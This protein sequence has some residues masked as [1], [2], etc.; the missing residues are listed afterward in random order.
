MRE[1]VEQSNVFH[2]AEALLDALL[3]ALAVLLADGVTRLS[4]GAPSMAPPPPAPCLA[5]AMLME[6][7]VL[8]IIAGIGITFRRSAGLRISP[9]VSGPLRR[10]Q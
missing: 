3:D 9:M 10:R 5:P 2:P 7:C 8:A 1:L 4:R 6:Q